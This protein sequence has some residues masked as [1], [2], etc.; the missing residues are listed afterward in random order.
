MIIIMTKEGIRER[1]RMTHL[2]KRFLHEAGKGKSYAEL[3]RLLLEMKETSKRI[4]VVDI[5]TR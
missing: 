2:N 5:T 1:L 4:D 3:K